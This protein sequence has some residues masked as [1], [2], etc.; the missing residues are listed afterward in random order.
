MP[1]IMVWPPNSNSDEMDIEKYFKIKKMIEE[2]EKAKKEKDKKK[3]EPP[4]FTFLEAVGFNILTLPLFG[5]ILY[6]GFQLT[7]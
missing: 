4:R 7:K 1:P 2:D 3:T 5:A 6:F